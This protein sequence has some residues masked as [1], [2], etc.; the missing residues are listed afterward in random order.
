MENKDTFVSGSSSTGN[1]STQPCHFAGHTCASFSSISVPMPDRLL[2][3]VLPKHGVDFQVVNHLVTQLH[4]R[5]RKD[6]WVG[7]VL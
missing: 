7:M 1:T 6:P 5:C 4:L 3:L 2:F